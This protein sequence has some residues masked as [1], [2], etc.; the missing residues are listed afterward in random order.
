MTPGIDTPQLRDIAPPVEVPST[1]LPLWL[2]LLLVL[3]G[4]IG[5]ALWWRHFLKSE[6]K[7][8]PGMPPRER[9]LRLLHLMEERARNVEAYQF[10]I[11]VSDL[12]RDYVVEA[13]GLAMPQQTS[14]EFLQTIRYER[15]FPEW[16]KE[17]LA[18]FLRVADEFK[19][20]HR[21]GSVSENLELLRQA[22]RFVEGQKLGES[23]ESETANEIGGVQT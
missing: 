4:L 6:K 22:V 3:L 19:Y 12:L 10:S 13:Y 17:L 1:A 2:I 5:L 21:D 8:A 7:R 20:A 18:S 14:E 9:S 23:K 15:V 16:H 11:E